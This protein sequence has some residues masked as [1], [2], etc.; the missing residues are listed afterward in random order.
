MMSDLLILHGTRSGWNKHMQHH[1]PVCDDCQSANTRYMADFRRIRGIGLYH[2]PLT[3][4]PTLADLATL[5]AVLAQG[6]RAA[7]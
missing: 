1:I 4:P 3:I 5:G 2:W 6:F 7:A